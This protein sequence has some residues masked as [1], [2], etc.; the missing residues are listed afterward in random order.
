VFLKGCPLRCLWCHNP[1]SY[2]GSPQLQFNPILCIGC[3]VCFERCA[4]G[5]HIEIDGEHRI[6]RDRCRSCF[7]C[8]EECYARALEL[9]GDEMTPEQVL[10][11]VL[12]D[13]PFYDQSGGGMTLSG[14]EPMAQPAF[15]LALL[16]GARAHGLHT[17]METCGFGRPRTSS[18]P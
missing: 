9:V 17:C 18:R 15:S 8:A 4:A 10:E 3:R 13:R 2:L 16:R 6:L 11:E 1:E 12:K 14:G 7:A 5:A